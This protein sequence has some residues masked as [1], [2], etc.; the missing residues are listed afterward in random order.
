MISKE[1][2]HLVHF[3]KCV[4]AVAHCDS[5]NV[6]THAPSREGEESLNGIYIALRKV[7]CILLRQCCVKIHR[8]R[9]TYLKIDIEKQNIFTLDL[10]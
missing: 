3:Y 7:R 2:G 10:A 4:H 5:C 6:C 9:Q 1:R 8:R